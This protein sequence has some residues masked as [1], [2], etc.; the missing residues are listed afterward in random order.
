MGHADASDVFQATLLNL[1]ERV[2]TLKQPERISAW[3]VTTAKNECLRLLR[4]RRPL[5][6]RWRPEENE[7]ERLVPEE[8]VLAKAR[9]KALWAAF[10][11]LSP[12]CQQLLRMVAY[13]PEYGSQQLAEAIGIGVESVSQTKGRCMQTLRLRMRE[14]R[15]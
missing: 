10:E 15:D 3:L 14:F 9:D 4:L 1:A 2:H 11:R 8:S 13:M 7:N 5:P 12:R 6:I